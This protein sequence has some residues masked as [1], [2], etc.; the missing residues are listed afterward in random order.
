MTRSPWVLAVLA[1]F[2]VLILLHGEVS[3]QESDEANAF[4]VQALQHFNEGRY[5]EALDSFNRAIELRADPIYYCNRAAVELK[6]SEARNALGSLRQC[7]DLYESE[8]AAEIN[9]IDAEI[10]GLEVF[11]D[12]VDHTSRSVAASVAAGLYGEDEPAVGDDLVLMA[13]WTT[14]GVAVLSLSAAL[15]VDLLTQPLL[16]E[17]EHEAAR[18]RDRAR[19]DELRATI[20]DRKVVIAS[21]AT[22]GALTLVTSGVLFWLHADEQV[23]SDPPRADLVFVDGGAVLGW[24]GSF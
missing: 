22:V 20:D 23:V 7:R 12:G 18:G 11:V 14:A 17:F 21:L 6:L 16:D 24:G 9:E 3:A 19:Y 1:F 15:T 13:A 8:D 4:Y 10:R 2:S 5:Q